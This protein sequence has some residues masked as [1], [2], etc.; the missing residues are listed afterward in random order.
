MT[1]SAASRNREEA[2]TRL[3]ETL[4][5]W[6]D[7]AGISEP[8]DLVKI[9]VEGHEPAVIDGIGSR[10]T[11]ARPS[12]SSSTPTSSTPAAASGTSMANDPSS[13]ARVETGEAPTRCTMTLASGSAD[14]TL[15]LWNVATRQELVVLRRHIGVAS[16]AFSQDGEILA[17]C[18]ADGSVK[19]WHSSLSKQSWPTR[20]D[21]PP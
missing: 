2:W 3:T 18:H 6:A 9:D 8:I 4:D 20:L 14:S 1:L 12:A 5:A 19:V 13:P 10:L 15:R 17:A 7:N 11:A 21:S 16:L